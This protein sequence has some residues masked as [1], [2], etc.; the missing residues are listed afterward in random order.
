LVTFR[1]G[2]RQIGPAHPPFVVAEIGINHDGDP[3]KAHRMVD[4][5][6]DAGVECVK[7]QTHVVDDE[8]IPN[9][10]VPGNADEPIYDMM[11]R[12]ALSE[13]EE[14]ELKQ[15]AEDRGLVFL[16]TP[17]SRAAADR[18]A[19]LD[20]AAFKIGS[21]ECNNYPLIQHIAGFGKPVILSTGMNDV[22]SIRPAVRILR[23]A[24][25]GFA[26][27]HCTSLY[28]TPPE[29]VRLG[30][31]AEIGAAFPDAV[32]G[33]SDHTTSI[34]PCL[35]AV[36]LGARVLER[37]FTSDMAWPGPDIPVSSTPAEF[38]RL[39]EGSR[40]IHAA[41]GGRKQILSAEQPTIDFAHACVVTTSAIAAGTQLTSENAW[42]K[43][44]GT[45]EIKAADYDTVL[46]RTAAKDLEA[47]AQ[48]RWADLV[49]E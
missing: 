25:V 3:A 42:V 7:F 28:P 9:D 21:G 26:L 1:I 35:G 44:P 4:D 45:G 18:L 30:A 41:L 24:G 27:L 47:D 14:R 16:S 15:H 40:L 23:A 46:G 17:F 11:L 37:H 43:R 22:K 29:L 10:V 2:D 31:L 32:L 34:Y 6:A 39:V 20:V 19:A 5:A 12:C 8:M 13:Q 36:P 38:A 33:L 48:I 49:E